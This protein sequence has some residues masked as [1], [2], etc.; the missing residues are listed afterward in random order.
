MK[1]ICDKKSLSDAVSIVQRAVSVKSTLPALEGILVKTA[2]NSLTLLAYDLEIGITT[3]LP[4]EIAE[5]GEIVLNARLFS[6]IVRRLPAEKVTVA[7]DQKLLTTVSSGVAEFTILGLSASEFP[8]TPALSEC[9]QAEVPQNMLAC[10]IRQTLFCVSADD[11]KPVHT[12]ALFELTETSLRIVAVDGYRLAIRTEELKNGVQLSFVVPGKTLSELLK[13]LGDTDEPAQLSVGKRHILFRV[14][15]YTVVSRLL[16]GDFLDYR[17]VLS[18]THAA[19]LRVNVR[20]F[21]ESVERASLL[22]SDRLKSP[23][24]CTFEPDRIKITCSTSTG[25][26][27]DEVPAALSGEPLEMGFNN[28]YLLDALR[29]AECDE[30][31]VLL[32]G[33]LA[34]MRICPP[35]GDRFLFLVL[36]VRLKSDV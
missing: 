1:F 27:Y 30:V 6:E 3:T 36:P 13:M 24:R 10:M 35:E 22:I 18:G 11:S 2:E 7:A 33:A 23:V 5:P 4:A 8:E 19:Q 16:E 26:V 32:S 34:P 17:S 20:A 29:A 31:R 9:E 25:K 15:R 28:R 14:G 21:S 12:G